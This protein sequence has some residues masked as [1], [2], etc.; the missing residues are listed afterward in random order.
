MRMENSEVIIERIETL[1]KNN[2]KHFYWFILLSHKSMIINM[3]KD[4][5][6]FERYSGVFMWIN[7]ALL[8]FAQN[9]LPYE[10]YTYKGTKCRFHNYAPWMVKP[11][12]VMF[13]IIQ[14]RHVSK[15]HM[16]CTMNSAVDNHQSQTVILK[17]TET[18][19][20]SHNL[21]VIALEN[22]IFGRTPTAKPDVLTKQKYRHFDCS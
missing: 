9:W 19:N 6:H 10:Q 2:L 11:W 16:Y 17:F 8:L 7:R 5:K 1:C 20:W 12:R 15:F 13:L 3:E 14:G 4:R 22:Q 21:P 18:E